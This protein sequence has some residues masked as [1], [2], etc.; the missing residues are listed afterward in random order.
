MKKFFLFL[1]LLP[2]LL[3]AQPNLSANHI[4]DVVITLDDFIG[5]DQYGSFYY[6]A[7]NV[8]VKQTADTKIEYSNVEKGRIARADVTNPLMIVLLYAD[9]N[10]VVL[11]DNQLN[12]ITEINFS[13]TEQQI[14]VQAVG[15]AEQNRLWIYDS[16]TQSI[17]LF[18]YARSN[19][20]S[21]A[22]PLSSGIG[23][24]ETTLTD[25]KWIDEAGSIYSIDIYGDVQKLGIIARFDKVAF[26][27]E[28]A[29]LFTENGKIFYC[30]LL[31]KDAILIPDVGN[32]VSK[33]YYKDQ[34]LSIFTKEGIKKY[35]LNL[36]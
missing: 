20:R 21:L 9:F 13:D 12:E 16:V 8:F 10:T 29:I 4:E 17:F 19:F 11:L 22:T 34:I 28:T 6:I 35:K 15:L 33:F 25:F 31:K 14:V 18:D 26:A 2:A 32:S 30:D 3:V 5:Y 7:N 36:P 1:L 27:S 24:Y 23:Y